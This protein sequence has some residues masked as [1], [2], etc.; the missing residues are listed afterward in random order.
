LSS[1]I[2]DVAVGRMMAPDMVEELPRNPPRWLRIGGAA[3]LLIAVLA[4]LVFGDTWLGQA[5]RMRAARQH[6]PQVQS[7]LV[8]RPEFHSVG[9][10]VG[11][12][13]GGCL[14]IT[15]KVATG[16]DLQHLKTSVAATHPPIRVVYAVH[17]G[18]GSQSP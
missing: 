5:R 7:V 10:G 14:L 12:G 17:V 4:Y 13:A 8:S 1:I 3:A 9:V 11:T 15:G 2:A 6:L 16:T 18:S